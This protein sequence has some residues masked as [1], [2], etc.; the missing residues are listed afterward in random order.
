MA[1]LDPE[2]FPVLIRK[3]WEILRMHYRASDPRLYAMKQIYKHIF[4]GECLITIKQKDRTPITQ[5]SKNEVLR[6]LDQ[7]DLSEVY[8]S[9]T[10]FVYFMIKYYIFDFISAIEMMDVAHENAVAVADGFL[11]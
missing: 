6:L 5:K 1:G 11:N 8:K 7:V 4:P 9:Y 2:P 10:S 3:S